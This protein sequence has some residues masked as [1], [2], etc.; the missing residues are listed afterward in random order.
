METKDGHYG[1]P[2]LCHSPGTGV[3]STVPSSYGEKTG[4]SMASPHVAALAALLAERG[5]SNQEIRSRIAKTAKDL[6]PE[7]R[8]RYYGAGR[9]NAARAVG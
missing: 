1:R 3:L 4:T 2:S 6:G 8:D 5:L 9:I 7:G